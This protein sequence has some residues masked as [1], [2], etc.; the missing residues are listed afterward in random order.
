[1][2]EIGHLR[3]LAALASVR[4]GVGVGVVTAGG[5]RVVELVDVRKGVS[6][7]MVVLQRIRHQSRV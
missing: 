4:V 3:P 7:S 5:N 6:L 1:M 2:S